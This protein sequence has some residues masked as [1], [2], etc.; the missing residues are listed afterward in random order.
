MKCQKHLFTPY[1]C[2][3]IARHPRRVSSGQVVWLC[4]KCDKTIGPVVGEK[5]EWEINTNCYMARKLYENHFGTPMPESL[6]YA[7]ALKQVTRAIGI[8]EVEK[9]I[10]RFNEIYAHATLYV[11]SQ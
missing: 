2:S 11:S 8:P 7:D 1:K 9:R 3:E 10:K 5:I 6:S 4:N